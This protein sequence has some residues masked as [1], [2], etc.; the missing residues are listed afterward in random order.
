MWDSTAWN[1]K[2]NLF[3]HTLKADAGNKSVNGN[4]SKDTIVTEQEHRQLNL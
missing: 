3:G 4:N 1:L 2:A